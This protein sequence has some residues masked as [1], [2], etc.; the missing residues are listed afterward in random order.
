MHI[1][2]KYL[3][4]KAVLALLGANGAL[5]VLALANV[6]LNVESELNSVSIVSYRSSREIQISGSTSEL[7]QF[8]IFAVVV[9]SMTLLLSIKLYSHRRHFAVGLLSLNIVTLLLCIVIFN[10]LTRT[11]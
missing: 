3:H 5:F 7:Y 6:L 10:A 4:D 9:S 1:P 2:Q 11:L 8:A